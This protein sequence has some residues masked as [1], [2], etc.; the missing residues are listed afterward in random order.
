MFPLLL[1]ACTTPTGAPEGMGEDTTAAAQAA[2]G[3][4]FVV[5]D[6]LR[7][8]HLT[9]Y[10]YAR[11]TMPSLDARPHLVVDGFHA[12]SS[13]TPPSVA[14]IMSGLT[15]PHHGIRWNP[16][17][18]SEQTNIP[19]AA[20]S[21]I[22]AFHDA[23]YSTF[24]STGNAFLSAEN[25]MDAGFDLTMDE[26]GPEIDNAAEVTEPAEGWLG[27]RPDDK[28]FFIWLQVMNPHTPLRPAAEDLGTWADLS[29][30]PKGAD[31][32]VVPEDPAFAEAYA[33]RDAAGDAALT[34]AVVDVYDE[35]LLGVDRSVEHLMTTL[36]DLG[37]TDVLL[38]LTSDHGE[39]L[40]E[41]NDNSWGHGQ[42][43]R[44]EL[45]RVPLWFSGPDV[46]AGHLPCLSEN[47]DLMPSIAALRS[48]EGPAGIDGQ[49][50]FSACRTRVGSDL[51]IPDN[52]VRYVTIED[53]EWRWTKS[54]MTRSEY[55][56]NAQTDPLERTHLPTSALPDEAAWTADMDERL[57]D[58]T[59]STGATCMW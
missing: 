48:V 43:L 21:F 11:E 7:A 23:G 13:W 34:Q 36:H 26:A 15:P 56:T 9:D 35:T 58:I 18:E 4:V 22:E 51:W 19:L 33:E 46:V 2:G 5:V 16:S 49:S 25:G 52:V 1:L 30:L 28:P 24:L 3:V 10:G 59:E 53:N 47:V 42:S 8:D 50:I 27:A 29:V 32:G 45:T 38:V 55:V 39:T 44:P 14:S 54:C 57:A 37:R 12:T 41:T 17:N 20:P 40:N 6:T 31:G